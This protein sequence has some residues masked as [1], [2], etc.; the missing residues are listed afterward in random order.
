MQT[1]DMAEYKRKLAEYMGQQDSFTPQLPAPAYQQQMPQ[2]PQMP[3]LGDA[4]NMLGKYGGKKLGSYLF[5]DA[6]AP[7]V[8][9]A[10]AP[11]A[12]A[13]SYV[14]SLG[15]GQAPAAPGAFSLSGIGSAGNA[16]LPAAGALGLYDVLSKKRTDTRGFLQGAASGAAMGSFFGPIGTGVG[17]VLGG[18]S[19]PVMGA[20]DTNRWKK[21]W[22]RRGK[23]GM[24]VSDRPTSGRSLEEL[25]NPSQSR[26]FV[27]MT[28]QGWVNNKFSQS[29]D[30]NDLQA[31]DLQGYAFLPEKFGKDLSLDQRL[32]VGQMLLDAKAVNEHH[33][34]MDYN[35]NFNA[36]LESKIREYLKGKNGTPSKA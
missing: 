1:F 3:G 28:P 17:A 14:G 31:M 15:L 33:G 6:A 32:G 23:L 2:Q 4:A 29:R 26:D 16:F 25:L 19:S 36:D 20:L 10:T 35:E 7:E 30:K 22:D 9:S 18:L 8:F 5:S 13:N 21:E 34:T 27:G 12:A 11:E 24:D